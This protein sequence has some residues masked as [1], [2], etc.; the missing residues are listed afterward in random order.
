MFSYCFHLS[1]LMCFHSKTYALLIV[2]NKTAENADGSDR[3]GRFFPHHFL[4][5]SF[6]S[7]Y[8]R[9][10][11]FSES[12]VFERL[13]FWNRFRK[14]PVSSAFPGALRKAKTHLEVCVFKRERISVDAQK[15]FSLLYAE[16]LL[17]SR[18][19]IMANT[20]ITKNHGQYGQSGFPLFLTRLQWYDTDAR[21]WKI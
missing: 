13:H 18:Q 19:K 21:W 20:A 6:S 5:P 11:A 9:N 17:V 15:V 7:I 10:G 8:N 3:I 4:K 16:K 2:R 1:T 14:S 12:C